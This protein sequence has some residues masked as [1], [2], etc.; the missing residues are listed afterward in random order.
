MQN[1]EQLMSLEARSFNELAYVDFIS[2]DE[3]K[4]TRIDLHA[5]SNFPN[6]R[7]L[8]LLFNKIQTLKGAF[9]LI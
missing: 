7:T 2:L 6:L 3:C 1:N 8:S 9:L 4:L 5:F